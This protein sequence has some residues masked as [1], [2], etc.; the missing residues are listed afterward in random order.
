MLYDLPI[1]HSQNEVGNIGILVL[2][3]DREKL[4]WF[5][6]LTAKQANWLQSLVKFLIFVLIYFVKFS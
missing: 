5:D 3:R 2:W 4:Q 6:W 1:L